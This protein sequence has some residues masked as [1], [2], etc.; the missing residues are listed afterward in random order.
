MK[1]TP[2]R[3]L[4]LAILT[5]G[6]T[7]ITGCGGGGGGGGSDSESKPV[8]PSI[9]LSVSSLYL[10]EGQASRIP[11]EYAQGAQVS[12]KVEGDAVSASIDGDDLVVRSGDVDRP[13]TAAIAV[14][15]SIDG[16]QAAQVLS[17]AIY[18]T[19]A[20]GLVRQTRMALDD[21]D[22]LVNL[23][24]DRQLYTFFVDFAYLAGGVPYA[25]K[26]NLID[27]FKP[28]AQISYA[29][30]DL[31][32]SNLEAA[33]NEYE[34]GNMADSDLESVLIQAESLLADHAAY[35]ESRL[36]AVS[37][38]ADVIVPGF[39]PGKLAFDEVSGLYTRF[40]TDASVG[41]YID[42]QF[43]FNEPYSALSDLIR[44][45]VNDSAL[46]GVF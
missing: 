28:A 9:S 2:G 41:E 12:V 23:S 26:K 3:A 11:F 15:S 42:G 6:I 24:D 43:H 20:Q 14:T 45:G 35:G 25:D 36:L 21:R 37:Q 16:K 30:L 38:F 44:L 34:R 46:C 1:R 10:N 13:A 31:Q 5:L 4:S 39:V 29:P 33:L 7:L 32:L 18:N 8:E 17:V 19:S 27:Q 22:N 40:L